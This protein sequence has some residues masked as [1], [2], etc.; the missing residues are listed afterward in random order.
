M[1]AGLDRKIIR[2]KPPTI[3][4]NLIKWKCV[5]ITPIFFQR[6]SSGSEAFLVIIIVLT[7]L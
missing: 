6:I 2:K 3:K 7:L 1:T 5:V 4:K